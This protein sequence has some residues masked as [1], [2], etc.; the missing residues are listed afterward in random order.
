MTSINPNRTPSHISPES[1]TGTHQELA[2]H[3]RAISADIKNSYECILDY[4]YTNP[5]DDPLNKY[6]VARALILGTNY[7]R[8]SFGDS[9]NPFHSIAATIN[10]LRVIDEEGM[11]PECATQYLRNL[12][13]SGNSTGIIS[14]PGTEIDINVIQ[15]TGNIGSEE[16]P[17]LTESL[18]ILELERMKKLAG[19]L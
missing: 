15:D 2:N 4:A 1:T 13:S 7:I 19:I 10:L 9:E 18:C 8:Y 16:A 6:M 12:I 17:A 11:M 14:L 3:L 5:E